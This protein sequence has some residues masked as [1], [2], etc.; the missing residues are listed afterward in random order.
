VPAAP[1][2][3][4]QRLQCLR[5]GEVANRDPK[6]GHRRQSEQDGRGRLHPLGRPEVDVAHQ[7]PEREDGK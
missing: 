5:A 2:H 6:R 3:A 4:E 7:R 1:N